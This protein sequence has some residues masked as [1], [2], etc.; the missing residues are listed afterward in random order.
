MISPE[1]I[2]LPPSTADRDLAATLAGLHVSAFPGFF[3]TSLG[4]PF[5][6]L[7]YA[8]FITKPQG[9]CV[10]AREEGVIIG[11]AAGTTSPDSFFRHL[12]RRQWLSF[13]LASVPGL[14]RNPLF[15]V[16]KCLGAVFYRGESPE[17]IDHAALLS[18]L[19]VSP[20]F[21]GK[22]VGRHLVAAFADK[23]RAQGCDALYLT[24]DEAENEPVNQFYAKCGFTLRDTFR[25]PGNRIMNR[26]VM[27]L[28]G[29]L[30]A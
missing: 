4:R 17:G 13:A 7:L 23:A 18:S 1:I 20:L 2:V 15:V 27:D 26:W 14:L 8:G 6:R 28:R 21:S 25:R 24:T 12:L 3:L 9:V 30:P 19:A 5:L 11:F 22:G 29:I 10:V 16:R